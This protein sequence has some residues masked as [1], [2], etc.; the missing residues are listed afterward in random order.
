MKSLS[1]YTEEEFYKF[2]YGIH[3]ADRHLYPTERSHVNAVLEFKRLTQH[4]SG[5]NLIFKPREVGLRDHPRDM[6]NEVKRWRAEQGL[7]G[8]KEA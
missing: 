3:Q 1:D 7:P 2:V 4:P 6:V 5:S 8:F